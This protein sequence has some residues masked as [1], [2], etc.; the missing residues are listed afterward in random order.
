MLFPD[1]W[2]FSAENWYIKA[3]EIVQVLET[4]LKI[5]N[6]V[7]FGNDLDKFTKTHLYKQ[8]K[9]DHEFEEFGAW[10]EVVGL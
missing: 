10:F 2:E 7:K 9:E 3:E 4:E 1:P 5:R 8:R 6:C